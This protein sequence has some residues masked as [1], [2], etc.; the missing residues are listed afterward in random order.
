MPKLKKYR[1]HKLVEAGQIASVAAA[2]SGYV[3]QVVN[4]E[5]K[6]ESVAVGMNFF[7]RGVAKEGDYYIRYPDGYVSWSPKVAFEEGY[8]ETK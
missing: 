2:G 3:L 8:T 6:A 1:S 7:A 4:A 5:G